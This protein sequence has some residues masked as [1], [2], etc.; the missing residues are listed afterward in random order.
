MLFD[1]RDPRNRELM[2]AWV[3]VVTTMLLELRTAL[4]ETDETTRP[5]PPREPL[6]LVTPAEEDQG[7]HDPPV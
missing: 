6:R 1:V 2:L 3:D 4:A 5:P 7:T